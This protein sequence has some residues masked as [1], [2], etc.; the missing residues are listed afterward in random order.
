V[1]SPRASAYRELPRHLDA[2]DDAVI[3]A[4][5]PV[6]GDDPAIAEPEHVAGLCPGRH[7]HRQPPVEGL[8]L[9]LATERRLGD[10]DRRLAHHVPALP[11]QGGMR[12]HAHVHVEVAGGSAPLARLARAGQAQPLAVLDPGGHVHGQGAPPPHA[13]LALAIHAGLVDDRA[14]AA[15]IGARLHADELAERRRPPD[16]DL[17]GASTGRAGARPGAGCGARAAAGGT[18]L[19]PRERHLAPAAEGGLLEGDLDGHPQVVAAGRPRAPAGA[20]AEERV[21][22][23][24]L[25]QVLDVDAAHAEAAR[26]AGVALPGTAAGLGRAIRLMTDLVIAGTLLGVAQ[27]RIGLAD[28]LEALGRRRVTRI[29][30]GVVPARELAKGALDLRLIRAAGDAE[31]LVVVAIGHG[32]SLPRRRNRGPRPPPADTP[33][34][35]EGPEQPQGAPDLPRRVGSTL[36]PAGRPQAPPLTS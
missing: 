27:H 15:A 17:P 7:L 26:V 8:H 22:Q 18:G 6:D 30:V 14:L 29:G 25:K 3:A 1:R 36:A 9:D 11:P 10:A 24:A 13:A 21:A 12:G 33:V 16:A 5:A 28:L 20:A 2:D 19:D 35:K 32:P 34:D 23:D 31:H 4:V